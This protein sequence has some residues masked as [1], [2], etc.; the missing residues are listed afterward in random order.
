M[1]TQ[2]ASVHICFIKYTPIYIKIYI[3]SDTYAPAQKSIKV[4]G[5]H[6][7]SVMEK[8]VIVIMI[9]GVG[10]FPNLPYSTKMSDF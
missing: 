5:Q 3:V 2:A 10:F 9:S 4:T 6:F 7:F 1:Y 8:L